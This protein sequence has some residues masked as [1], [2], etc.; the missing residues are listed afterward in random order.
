[1]IRVYSELE[2]VSILRVEAAAKIFTVT[3]S[4]VL[5]AAPNNSLQR[6][7]RLTFE[8]V[9]DCDL[10]ENESVCMHPED[11]TESQVTSWLSEKKIHE[12]ICRNVGPCEGRV[13]GQINSMLRDAPEFFYKS[14]AAQNMCSKSL[15]PVN[16]VT[17]KDAALFAYELKMLFRDF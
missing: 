14:I 10:L 3:S 1:M 2:N 4:P 11:W 5:T 13:L 15:S 8:P 17:T 7:R 9:V 12:D 6:G 16:F